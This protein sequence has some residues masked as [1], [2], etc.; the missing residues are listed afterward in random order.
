MTA[1]TT[2]QTV[3]YNVRVLGVPWGAHLHAGT[4]ASLADQREYLA[5]YETTVRAPMEYPRA[6]NET[7]AEYETRMV[8]C[9]ASLGDF[10]E[11]VALEIERRT[12][13]WEAQGETRRRVTEWEVIRSF[14]EEAEG[15][16]TDCMFPREDYDD[17]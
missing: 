11:V 5:A 12:E 14:T 16:F 9:A 3:S 15:V 17:E 10:S 7:N 13:Q 1:D 6:D 4:L 8:E 2:Q